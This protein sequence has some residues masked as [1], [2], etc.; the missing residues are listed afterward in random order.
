M[1]TTGKYPKTDC[2]GNGI[3][4]RYCPIKTKGDNVY[5]FE[6]YIKVP[7]DGDYTFYLNAANKAFMRIHD[8]S[9][10]DEDY[11]YKGGTTRDGTIKLK[12]GFHPIRIY[13]SNDP[14]N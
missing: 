2:Y 5:L 7:A 14:K 6:G 12:A 13:Y 9:V 10:I 4:A 1:A 8:A 11:D 3:D